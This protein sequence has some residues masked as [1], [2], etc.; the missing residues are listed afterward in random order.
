MEGE[1]SRII[2][3]SILCFSELLQETNMK[4]EVIRSL[5]ALGF[6]APMQK[7]HGLRLSQ[8]THCELAPICVWTC[9]VPQSL[10]W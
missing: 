5:G 4:E 7:P 3:L 9:V 6:E 2:C 8:K 10:C 1:V